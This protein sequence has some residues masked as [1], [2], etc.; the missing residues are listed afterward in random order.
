M[1][2]PIEDIL[3][4]NFVIHVIWIMM[5]YIVISGEIICTVIS[6]MLMA[7]IS[8]IILTISC[9]SI[10]ETNTI[11]AKRGNVTMKNSLQYLELILISKR[12]GLQLIVRG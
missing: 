2:V 8:I 11:Y 7:F 9:E 5:N 12:I 10:F 3:S 1:I 4:V 6:V